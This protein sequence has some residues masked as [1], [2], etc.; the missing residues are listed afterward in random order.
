[1][2]VHSGFITGIPT[3]VGSFPVVIT[4]ADSSGSQTSQ[5]LTLTVVAGLTITSASLP[6]G[7]VGAIYSA[8]LAQ[9]TPLRH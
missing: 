4:V 1:M 7:Q 3:A 2:G 5:T 6:E 8:A 9:Q